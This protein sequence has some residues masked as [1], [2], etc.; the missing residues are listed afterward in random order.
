MSYSKSEFPPAAQTIVAEIIGRLRHSSDLDSILQFTVKAL[1]EACQADGALIWQIDGDCLSATNE[2]A[3]HGPSYFLGNRISSME[4]TAIVLGFL[5]R[6][7]DDSGAGVIAVPDTSQDT[8]LKKMSPTLSS[9]IELGNVQARLLVQ[10]RSRGRFAGILELQLRG[11]MREWSRAEA[12]ILQ[13]VGDMLS[14]VLQQSFDQA[15]IEMDAKDMRLINEILGLS[16]DS[17][18]KSAQDVLAQSVSLVADHMGFAH[19]QIYLLERAKG[20]LN[21]QIQNEN[22]KPIELT[23]KDNPFVSVLESARGKVIN[24]ETTSEGNSYFGQD[25]ALILPLVSGGD[26]LGVFGLWKRLPGKAMF[27]PQDRELGLTIAGYLAKVVRA[28]LI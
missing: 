19:A 3:G 11:R 23:K 17:T 2:F 13:R 28:A 4:S 25:M 27:R 24:M 9:L 26:R 5:S 22:S 14:I 1:A 16:L 6:F 21:P 7:P 12:E 18:E 20:L 15:R 10:L 8:D